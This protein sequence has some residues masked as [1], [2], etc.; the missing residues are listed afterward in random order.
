MD[1]VWMDGIG[2]H[3]V[4][5]ERRAQGRQRFPAELKA[6]DSFDPDFQYENRA[7]KWRFVIPSAYWGLGWRIQ[8]TYQRDNWGRRASEKLLSNFLIILNPFEQSCGS[9]QLSCRSGG[10]NS[11]QQMVRLFLSE[12]MWEP[13]GRWHVAREESLNTSSTSARADDAQC[14]VLYTVWW[15]D[16]NLRGRRVLRFWKTVSPV[17]YYSNMKWDRLC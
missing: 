16:L 1:P 10:C 4:R 11:D 14:F 13:D 12:Q 2:S 17:C 8:K 6:R 9:I 5:A 3:T 7:W 15:T